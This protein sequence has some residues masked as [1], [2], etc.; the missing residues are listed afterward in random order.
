MSAVQTIL[1]II[2]MLVSLVM[3]VS[4]LLQKGDED[5]IAALGGSSS[6]DSHYGKNKGKTAAGK[7]ASITKASAVVF[8]ALTLIMLFVK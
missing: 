3:I 7:L 6:Q 8:V 5:G 2:L 4:V 1:T